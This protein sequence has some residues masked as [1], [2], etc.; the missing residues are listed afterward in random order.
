MYTVL[1]RSRT[2]SYDSESTRIFLVTPRYVRFGTS[3]ISFESI[4]LQLREFLQL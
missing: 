2:G 4:I 3:F 1:V